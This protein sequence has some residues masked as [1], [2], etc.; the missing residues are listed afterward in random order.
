MQAGFDTAFSAQAKPADFFNKTSDIS[1][2]KPARFEKEF[3]F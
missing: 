1:N 2:E 3:F